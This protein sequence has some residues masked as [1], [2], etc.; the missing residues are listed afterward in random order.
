MRAEV[1]AISAARL[2]RRVSQPVA[3]DEIGRL[4]GTMNRMLER[5][6][7]AQARQRRFVAD[8]SHELRSPIAAIRQQA[9]VALAHPEQASALASV[10]HA[11]S[12]RM[13]ALVEDL[14]LLARADDEPPPHRR[15][16]V[17]VD[18]LVL[19]EAARLRAETTLRVDTTGVAAAR[20]AGDA[21]ALRRVLRN[22][23]DN[24]ARHA[25]QRIGLC[26]AQ[27]DGA[28]VLCVDDDGP[29]IPQA[30]RDR[31]F[32]RFVRLDEGRARADGGS[33]LGLAIVAEVVRAH[34]GAVAVADSPLG[35]A[36]VTVRL[37]SLG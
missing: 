24:A 20:V 17:D 12:L 16:A 4:A 22:L 30:E 33:G 13:Q 18:D 2:H 31:V 25:T 26:V 21:A 6:E 34:G 7:A 29:G 8:A 37:P 19:A 11:E 27:R 14:L 32:E 35:G 10:V 3:R 28:A 5:V 1:D 15:A 9:E 23:V 36:R